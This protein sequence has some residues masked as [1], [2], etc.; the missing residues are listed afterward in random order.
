MRITV[1]SKPSCGGCTATKRWLD[2]RGIQY[3]E[4]NIAENAVALQ[5]VKELGYQSAPV[6]LI[7]Y[8]DGR[9]I[10]WSGMRPD[11]LAT[12]VEGVAAA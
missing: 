10:H 11:L 2:H 6:V 7:E 4:V 3:S 5:E 12:H 9:T 1:F 8:P